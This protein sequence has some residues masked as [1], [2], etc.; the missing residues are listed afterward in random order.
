MVCNFTEFRIHDMN[1]PNDTPETL[2]LSDL[3]KEYPRLQF[4][5]DTGNEDIKREMEVSLQAGELVGVLYSELLKRYIDPE[6]PET[7]KHLNALCV[8]LVF[9]LYAEDAGIFGGHGK[10]HDYL[11]AR[12][13]TAR[14]A[15]IDLFHVLNQPEAE[16]IK[17][18]AEFRKSSNRPQTIA[19]AETPSLFGEIRQP[20]TPMLAIP[21]VSSEHRKYIPICYVQP[22]V[23]VNG[24]A[25]IIP[26]AALYH[27]GVLCSNVH[28]SWMRTVAGRLEMRYQYS[29]T[30]VYN[31][32]PW[33]TPSD[34]QKAKIT[35]AAQ[36]IL[37]ARAKYPDC[38]LADLYDEVTMPP[39]LRK[40]HQDN[41]RAVMQAYDFW[42][43]LNTETACVAALMK[44]Y[45]ALTETEK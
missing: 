17:A 11:Q 4:L 43:K 41:D 6:S 39:E 40:A 28:N 32:F 29:N 5:I 8:R 7:L 13:A 34:A 9:C 20:D 24:S 18:V 14:Q 23:I 36:A 21:K 42:G 27:F 37:D 44:L 45:Q 16:R 10:F 30:V 33:S 19:L 22:E 12:Q 31:N 25:L 26:G 1:R 38:S 3:E 15:L 35:E 2:L